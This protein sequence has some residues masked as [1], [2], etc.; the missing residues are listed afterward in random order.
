MELTNIKTVRDV[1]ERHGVHFT[2]SL[3]QNFIINPSICPKIAQL[4][5]VE[6]DTRVLE[7]GA[8]V[9]VLTSELAKRAEKV[10]C[11]ELDKSLFPI[12]NETLAE[13]NNIRLI[14]N[15]ILK[16]DLKSL[17]EEE[18]IGHK[19]VV[20]ANLPYY[21]TSPV[22]MRL[23]EEKLPVNSITVMV[24]KE[25]AAR[26][27]AP[28]PSRQAG[29]ITVAVRYYCEPKVLFNVSR[30]SFMPAPNVD[31]AVI[32]LD[33]LQTPPV[34]LK[35]EKLFFAVIKG[36][37]SQRRKTLL[38]CLSSYFSIE[39]DKIKEILL[40]AGVEPSARAEQLVLKDFADV[41]NQMYSCGIDSK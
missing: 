26:I 14:N 24:Q 10:V 21:I 30:G 41:A 3:G 6:P 5:G 2:K 29:A 20:C 8:G 40:Q 31:S 22:I 39:K 12:L 38:N 16:I 15:D 35:D 28:L 1:M 13:F 19:T 18:F 9:G 33:R 32:R 7:I 36:A 34:D 23:L 25:A 17:F 27:C 37:Y 4:G 11:I